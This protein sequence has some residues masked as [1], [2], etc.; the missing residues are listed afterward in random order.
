L[1]VGEFFSVL[2]CEIIRYN[3]CEHVDTGTAILCDQYLTCSAVLQASLTVDELPVIIHSTVS[4][5]S[6]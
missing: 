6:V 2:K 5:G 1:H 3:F 4:L